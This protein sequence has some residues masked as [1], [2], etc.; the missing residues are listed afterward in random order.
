MTARIFRPSRGTTSS[1]TARTKTWV[2]QFEPSSAREI[3]PLM[4]WTSSNDMNSQV[5][6]SFATK[7][8]AIA[9]CEREG[10]AYL[11]E[12]PQREV[13]KVLSYSDNFKTSRPNQWT[14]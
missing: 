12:E 2:L 3:E 13:R 14:H 8:E 7:E 10:L 9:Y 1:G 11:V 4:G 5:K 6:L